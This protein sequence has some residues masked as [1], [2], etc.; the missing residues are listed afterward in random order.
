MLDLALGQTRGR[1]HHRL[2]AFGDVGVT[3][4]QRRGG[5]GRPLRRLQQC[6]KTAFAVGELL[7]LVKLSAI[8]RQLRELLRRLAKIEPQ[9]CVV[10]DELR[11]L[12]NQMLTHQAFERCRLLVELSAGVPG[13]R[14]LQYRLLALRSETIETDDQL[15]QRVE[16]RQADEQEAEQDELE[17]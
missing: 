11:I 10:V 8:E 5:I 3:F 12:E 17:E 13:L 15:D 9:A 7:E 16:Q 4:G 6:E 2:C 14:R 1:G